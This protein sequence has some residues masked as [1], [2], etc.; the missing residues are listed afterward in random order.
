MTLIAFIITIVPLGIIGFLV[1][2]LLAGPHS[3]ILPIF[4]QRLVVPVIVLIVLFLP[5]YVSAK[6]YRKLKLST[7]IKEK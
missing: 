3:G 7:K 4:L 1:I 2:I 5:F 6:V